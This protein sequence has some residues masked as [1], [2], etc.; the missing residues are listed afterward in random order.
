MIF[1][2]ISKHFYLYEFLKQ[3]NKGI[4]IMVFL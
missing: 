3:K 2:T 1:N 4:V